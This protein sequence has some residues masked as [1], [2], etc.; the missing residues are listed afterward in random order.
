ML[1][2]QFVEKALAGRPDIWSMFQS[3]H[4]Q[5]FSFREFDRFLAHFPD[6]F[7]SKQKKS[8]KKHQPSH[9]VA[10]SNNPFACLQH[11]AE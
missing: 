9:V 5:L 4:S 8:A 11:L 2:E 7:K 1:A 3:L 6:E 10:T